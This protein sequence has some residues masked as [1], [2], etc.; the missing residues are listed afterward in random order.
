MNNRENAR[1]PVNFRTRVIN[2]FISP[3]NIDY[4]RDVFKKNIPPSNDMLKITLESLIENVYSFS[5]TRAFD[6]LNSDPI[7]RRGAY[8]P[9]L[10]FWDEVKRLNNTFYMER[11]RFIHEIRPR[12]SAEDDQDEPYHMRMFVSDSLR[13]PGLEH[14]NG[15][16]PLYEIR[17]EQASW[18]NLWRSRGGDVGARN[19]QHATANTIEESWLTNQPDEAISTYGDIYAWGD[20]WRENGGTRAM[21]YEEIPF[22]QILNRRNGMEKN[23]EE[24]LGTAGREFEAP[25]R[26]W[27]MSRLT[28]PRGQ[29]YRNYG[30]RT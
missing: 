4:L 6:V 7:A 14:M 8:T 5:R 10:N 18:E 26:G 13:P 19:R 3:Q 27:D 24:T 12:R 1:V 30:S 21:R 22:W 16:G 20:N 23:I 15:P 29:E 11:M 25:V 28:N 17:E 9:A 2:Q